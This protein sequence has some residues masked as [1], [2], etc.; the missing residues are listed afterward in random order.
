MRRARPVGSLPSADS[1][2]P[3]AGLRRDAGARA[4]GTGT[5]PERSRHRGCDVAAPAGTRA[6]TRDCGEWTACPGSASPVAPGDD[7]RARRATRCRAS[8]D[9]SA[10]RILR[11]SAP[12]AGGR[13]RART[14][15]ALRTRCTARELA[16]RDDVL[17]RRAVTTA[18]AHTR[19]PR[20]ARSARRD[21]RG[22]RSA[23]REGGAARRHRYCARRAAGWPGSGRLRRS[24][25]WLIHGAESP[26]ES[27]IR[28]ALHDDGFP[29]PNCSCSIGPY[30][31]DFYW[32]RVRDGRSKPTDD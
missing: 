32:P 29:P 9:R 25:R 14:V 7:R 28:L 12:D 18:G 23:L 27:L 17:V 10:P 21:H 11:S 16:D 5:D 20:P 19:R 8:S 31:V 13:R 3:P 2:D 24:W 30:R 6:W 15:R 26:L 1:V 22:R 4:L